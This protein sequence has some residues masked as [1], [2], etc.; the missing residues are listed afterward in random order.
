MQTRLKQLTK[1]M[2]EHK[3]DWAFLTDPKNVYYFSGFMCEPN[4]RLLAL[5]VF[6]DQEP[7]LVCPGMEAPQAKAAGWEAEI[8]GY[9]DHEDPWEKM[10]PLL[11]K[12]G[13][14]TSETVAIETETLSFARSEQLRQAAGA[15]QFRSA[16]N[17][18]NALRMVKDEKELGSLEK[19]AE[20]ADFAISVGAGA[21]KKGKTEQSIIAE[22]EYEMK[23]RGVDSMSFKT[24]VLVGPNSAAPHGHPGN[25]QIREGD[26]VLFDLG[27]VVD[28]YCS[29]ITRT[30]VYKHASEE[31]EKIYNTVLKAQETA[32]Q[33]AQDGVV[34]GDVDRAARKVITD[35]GYGDYFPHRIGH[36]LGL[37]IHDAP[38]M[39]GNNTDL[40]R[41]GMVFTI[42]PGIYVPEVGGVRIEDDV[43]LSKDGAVTLT[44]YPK[45]LQIIE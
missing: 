31:Q 14:Q 6:P 39:S 13:R 26:F 15:V 23:K 18:I 35:A 9:G 33:A 37:G 2:I 38:S 21:I 41:T 12:R 40:L 3:V 4:E 43:Y 24:M 7:F 17:A 29:D 11:H 22:I 19:A 10:K 16:E 45:H 28:G 32:I 34:I 25:R 5:A 27:V 20:L 8:L 44:N 42:E 30:L 1:W 36:G